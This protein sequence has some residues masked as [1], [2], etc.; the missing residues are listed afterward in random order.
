[1]FVQIFVTPLHQVKSA[2]QFNFF[3]RGVTADIFTCS[4]AH[5]NCHFTRGYFMLVTVQMQLGNIYFLAALFSFTPQ[6]THR[7]AIF[8]G[9]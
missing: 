2:F 4:S 7:Q 1:M 5:D 9:G 8:R 3:G 6:A